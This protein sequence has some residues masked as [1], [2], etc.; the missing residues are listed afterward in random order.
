MTTI[1]IG[2]RLVPLEHIALFEPFDPAN[3]QKMRSD[4]PFQ[5]RIVLVNRESVL[6]EEAL[7]ALAEQNGFRMLA[8]DNVAANP[9]VLFSVE[10]F[11]AS[12]DFQPTKPY[13]SRLLWR[14]PTGKAQSKLLLTAPEDVLALVVRGGVM[15]AAS[16]RAKRSRKSRRSSTSP[17]PL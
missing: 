15:S 3:Q 11:E 16:G 9:A 1:T 6:T 2:K 8:E 7:S 12:G 4:K 10:A 13:R 14:D 17:A 5:T